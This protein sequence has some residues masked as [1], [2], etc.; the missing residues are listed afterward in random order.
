M[1]RVLVVGGTLALIDRVSERG[2]HVAVVCRTSGERTTHDLDGPSTTRDAVVELVLEAHQRRPFDAVLSLTESGLILAAELSELIGIEATSVDAVSLLRDK[3]AMREKL[4]SDDR[5]AV[6]SWPVPSEDAL[7]AILASEQA[8]VIVKPAQ[9]T[10][11]VGVALVRDLV[12]V[13]DAWN[14]M[15]AESDG[16]WIAEE[17]LSGP[18]YSVEVFSHDGEHRIVAI[19]EKHTDPDS[20]VELAHIVPARLAEHDAQAISE[21]VRLFLSQ[22]GIRTGPSHTEV[23]LTGSGPRVIESHNRIGGDK[24]REL[25][26]RA[27]GVDLLDLTIDAAIGAVSLPAERPMQGAA[28]IRFLT[29]PPGRIATISTP[30]GIQEDEELIIT[31]RPGDES[32]MK[33]TSSARAG[34]ALVSAGSADA[35]IARAEQI[36]NAV[37]FQVV[38]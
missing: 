20:F 31:G 13:A 26:R 1:I 30:D 14:L 7:A 34:Y 27:T 19:T 10:A 2:F 3:V 15:C 36:A 18:E 38:R 35:A 32:P 37:D 33:L 12:D 21:Q 16:P 17:F 28:A 24:I 23:K 8:P 5:L 6:R 29:P 11:S 25:V 9:G 22:I 4:S